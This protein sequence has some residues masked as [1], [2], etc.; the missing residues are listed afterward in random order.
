VAGSW[1]GDAEQGQ[2]SGGVAGVAAQRCGDAVLAVETQDADGQG[3]RWLAMALGVLP[4]RTWGASSP[5]VVS[6]RWCSASMPQWPRRQFARG[7]GWAWAAV[8]LVTADTVTVRHHWPASG[9]IR[10]VMRIAWAA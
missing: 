8:R 4:V 6:R 1:A 3:L 10:R 7:A 5:K 9:R 2:D